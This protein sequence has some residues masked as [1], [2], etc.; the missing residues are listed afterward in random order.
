[1]KMSDYF[2]CCEKCFEIIGKKNTNA[3]RI[4]MDLCSMRMNLGEVYILKTPDFPELRI[5]ENLGF[6]VSTEKPNGIA[7]RM[8][9]HIHTYDNQHFFCLKEGQHD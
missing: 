7:I 8:T 1:M 5:L 2:I 3:A 4:W 9:G 6:V